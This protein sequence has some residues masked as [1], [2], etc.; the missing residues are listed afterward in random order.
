[1]DAE[2]FEEDAFFEAV[3]ASGVR[4]LLIGRRALIALGFPVQT[5]DYD[6][7]IDIDQIAAFNATA[8]PFGCFPK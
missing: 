7:W 1:V 2:E 3:A 5:S 4:A 6:F 8:E